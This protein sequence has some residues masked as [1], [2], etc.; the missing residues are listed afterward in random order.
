[1]KLGVKS[2][3]TK[4]LDNNNNNNNIVSINIKWESSG[5]R[6]LMENQ[7]LVSDMVYLILLP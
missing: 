7:Y 4:W 6:I 2:F 1:M 5:H 3:R